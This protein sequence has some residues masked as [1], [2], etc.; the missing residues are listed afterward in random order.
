LLRYKFQTKR[1]AEGIL[2]DAPSV[3]KFISA[4]LGIVLSVVGSPALA[5]PPQMTGK[6]VDISNDGTIFL[7]YDTGSLSKSGSNRSFWLM[8]QR[9]E[10][11][12]VTP[13][14]MMFTNVSCVT[15]SG[16]LAQ[17]VQTQDSMP[18]IRQVNLTINWKNQPLYYRA[19]LTICKL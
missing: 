8:S 13:G 10:G 15:F 1:Q 9:V 3:K 11:I 5:N 14:F 7:S 19:F 6:F 4:A 17:I 18:V 12:N 16:T 2:Y